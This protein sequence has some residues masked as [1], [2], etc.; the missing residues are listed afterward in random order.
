MKIAIAQI[1]TTVGDFEGNAAKIAD[2]MRRAEREGAELV[3]FPELAITGYPPRDLLEKPSFIEA[4]LKALEALA[5]GSAKTAA[6]VGFVSP[7]ESSRGRALYNSAALLH[8]GR[9]AFVQHKTLLPQYD[10]FD[11]GRHFEPASEHRVFELNGRRLGLSLCEDLWSNHTFRGRR[12]YAVNP[13]KMLRDAGAEIVL[14]ISAS[15]YTV[16]KQALRLDL[17]SAEARSVGLPVFYCNLVGGNDELVFDGRSF[18][19]DAGGRP[20]REGRPF[21]EDFFVVDSGS[22]GAPVSPA[23][24]PEE[25]EI[26]R[27]L[28]LGLADYMRKCGFERAVIGL[29]GG[30]DSAV[31]AAIACD[32]IG[33]DRVL[34]VM[35]PSPYTGER[36][37]R[38]G[39][40][41][42]R[43]LGISTW[44]VPIGEV[45][46]AYRRAL[47]YALDPGAPVSLAEENIQ[48]RIRGNILMAVSNRDGSLVISTG[49]KSELSVGYCT[50]YGDMAG[51]FAL[52]SDIPKTLVYALARRA[53]RGGERIPKG[54]IDRPPSAELKPD[55]A[56]TDTLPAYDVLDPIMRH[57]IEDRM[58]MEEIVG[59]GFDTG[60]VERIVRMIDANEYKRRQAPPGI[61]I[62]MKAF[63]MG[64]RF[65]IARKT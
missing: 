62:T 49:N 64:R 20:V 41:L 10:V 30:I 9:V 61:K 56:D 38:D 17:F 23:A 13:A 33:R 19:L 31:V 46:E 36:S 37:M 57:Y 53:N 44:Q 42:A 18:A 39:E 16:G 1:N 5:K 8:G 54:I 4:N 32:A 11:E 12:L 22:M 6:V 52:I 40:A 28:V 47:G 15:P 34:G 55:Q 21:E 35:M 51:G 29:S 27:A 14:N 59:R 26:W 65:P 58:S 60:T 63:G 43:N 3:L 48:A 25:D 7:N 24:M 50:L 2:G 45:Y